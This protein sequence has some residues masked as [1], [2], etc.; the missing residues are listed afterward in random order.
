MQACNIC[1]GASFAGGPNNRMSKTG[2]PPRCTSCQSLER[3]RA[4]RATISL[5]HDADFCDYR[6][7]QVSNDR[8]AE[9]DWFSS[10]EV[11]V[12]GT[13]TSIDLQ[14]I[15]RGTGT[16]DMVIC[17]HVME[18]VPYD[19]SALNEMSRVIKAS[20]FVFLT[21]P[22]PANIS[23]TSDWGYP[24]ED[25]HGHYRVYGRDIEDRLRRYIPHRW[26]LSLD[27]EDPVTNV[28][29]MVYFILKS[30]VGVARIL[31]KLPNSKVV[32]KPDVII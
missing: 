12:Y 32:S 11:S 1:G 2:R 15:D 24:R 21:V 28:Q 5:L 9:R 30:A 22:D 31:S 14:K 25:Q 18:H 16:Y 27:T 3:H 13:D 20:G 7:L 29:D 19:N 17:N 4:A 6:V 26:V 23:I 10:F 8:C